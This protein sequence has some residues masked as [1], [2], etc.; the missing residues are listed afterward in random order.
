MALSPHHNPSPI[1][2]PCQQAYWV[3]FMWKR[4]E[5]LFS[6]P[7]SSCLCPS[8]PRD[9]VMIVGKNNT[10]KV[11]NSWALGIC[12]Y[13]AIF[14]QFPSTAPVGEYTR[15]SLSLEHAIIPREIGRCHSITRQDQRTKRK[16]KV[17]EDVVVH[18]PHHTHA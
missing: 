17:V 1:P 18:T 16:M 10:E 8:D 7:F 2:V 4:H 15:F 13:R 9:G 5:M 11:I 6:A 14:A 3:L 12:T